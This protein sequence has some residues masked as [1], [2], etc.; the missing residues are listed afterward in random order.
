LQLWLDGPADKLVTIL[1]RETKG[2][3]HRYAMAE[4]ADPAL[5]WLDGRTMGDLLD[6]SWRATAETLARRGRPVRLLTLP[7]LDE[8]TLGALFMH[9]ELETVIAAALFDVE[10]FDQPAVEDGKRLARAYLKGMA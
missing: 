10:P 3:G 6:V 5:D 2:V 1:A 4:L 8:R 9:F 7:T